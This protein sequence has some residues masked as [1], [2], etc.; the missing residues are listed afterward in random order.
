[1]DGFPKDVSSLIGEFAALQGRTVLWMHLG[2]STGSSIDFH[3]SPRI[4]REVPLR[5][6]I[7]SD[8]ARHYRGEYG[9]FI[10]CAWRFV[11]ANGYVR[12][13]SSDLWQEGDFTVAQSIA[14]T[15]EGQAIH[16][17]DVGSLRLDCTIVLESGDSIEVLC[18]RGID[19]SDDY[20]VFVPT[21][22]YSISRGQVAF[23]STIQKFTPP[24]YVPG[25]S[26]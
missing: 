23:D 25:E 18:D 16:H 26:T 1:M 13:G 20:D 5:N 3:F 17:V 19:C 15:I 4:R 8:D 9:L 6:S 2:P 12:L 21:G 22:V 14:T 24:G 7:L 11:L 10:H